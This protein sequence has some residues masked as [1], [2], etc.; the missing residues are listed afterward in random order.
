MPNWYYIILSKI[1]TLSRLACPSHIALAFLDVESST[2]TFLPPPI[3]K[4]Q[5]LPQL[6]FLS[7]P[8]SL[9]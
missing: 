9:L 6:F 8:L 5:L 4:P 1:F 7:K 3:R 2:I